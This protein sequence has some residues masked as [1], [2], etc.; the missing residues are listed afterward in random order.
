VILDSFAITSKS[1]P[2]QGQSI[3]RLAET[4]IDSKV[5]NTRHLLVDMIIKA[6]KNIYLEHLYFY[7]KYI[8]DALIKKKIEKPTIDIRVILD[9]NQDLELGGLPNTIFLEEIVNSG[10]QVR[11]RITGKGKKLIKSAITGR[12]L[13]ALNHRKIISIDSKVLMTGSSDITPNALQGSSREFGAQVFNPKIAKKFENRFSKDWNDPNKLV[14]MDI[15]NF[16]AR[17]D[18]KTLSK[19]NSN[20]INKILSLLLRSKDELEGR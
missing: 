9:P 18:G 3:L 8:V 5:V 17:L 7:D 4:D 6:E 19:E 16:R 14:I 2:Y 11:S 13:R 1:I 10:I 15:E 12:P 20:L